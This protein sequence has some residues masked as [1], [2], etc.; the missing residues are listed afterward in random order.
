MFAIIYMD[1]VDVPRVLVYEHRINY[2]LPRACFVCN[3]DFKLVE[4]IDKNKLRLDK[5]EFGKRNLRRLPETPY[6][7]LEG[8]NE[9]DREN[10][11]VEGASGYANIPEIPSNPATDGSEIGGDVCGSLDE[12]LQ[13]LPSSQE[14]EIPHRMLPIYEKH[15]KL[16]AAEVKN[17]LLSFGQIMKSIFCK[18]IAS[19]LVEANST[20]ATTKEQIS[21]DVTFH[22]SAGNAGNATGA[23][24]TRAPLHTSPA[25]HK[26]A[27]AQEV[28][29]DREV[30]G[31]PDTNQNGYRQEI[32]LDKMQ[33]CDKIGKVDVQLGK[34]KGEREEV[35]VPEYVAGDPKVSGVAGE[36]ERVILSQ[37]TVAALAGLELEFDDGPSFSLFKEGTEDYEWL[38]L[39]A[40]TARKVMETTNR[41]VA[42]PDV[43]Q[44]VSAGPT[45]DNSPLLARQSSS[46]KLPVQYEASVPCF[47]SDPKLQKSTD[48][49]QPIYDASPVAFAAPLVSSVQQDRSEAQLDEPGEKTVEA[50]SGRSGHVKMAVKKR[51]AQPPD[52]VPKMKKIKI[53]R[54]DDAL[55]QQYVMSR[56]KIPKPKKDQ[57]IPDFIEIEGFYTSLQNFHASLK[58]RAQIDCEVMTLY[59]KT[60]NLEQMYNKKKPKKFAFSVFMG[61][62]LAMDPDLFDHKKCEREFRRACESNQILKSDLLFITVVHNK[63][64]AVVVV[65][66]MHKQFNVFDSVKN[67]MDVT[68][69]HKATNN[70]ITNIKKVASSESS[71][72]FDLDCFEI[73]TPVYPKQSTHYNCGFFAILFLENFDGD[74]M[75]HFD[76][77]CIPNLRKRIAANLLKHPSNT[78]DPAEQLR[79]LLEL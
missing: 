40:E 43:Q 77:S 21:E 44:P 53:D 72:K 27:A 17:V 30:A 57:P 75:K 60:F 64:W 29:V 71:F 65:N 9:A 39:D 12:W 1:F 69:L 4:E 41:V 70:V 78:L 42:S 11:N 45:F 38:N 10:D 68:L 6:V 31:C 58:P 15:K 18:R 56:Y 8:S 50:S 19:I 46:S 67:P 33:S 2:S 74:V 59:L 52:G 20:A 66:L 51:K 16:H 61:T 7:S 36:D 79:K 32:V 23:D 47:D 37:G 76:E 13:P 54:K 35:V 25:P 14:L 49:Q 55:Y 62:Q 26:S 48:T 5:I 3:N 73:V 28:E 63:H 22:A 34:D 24:H